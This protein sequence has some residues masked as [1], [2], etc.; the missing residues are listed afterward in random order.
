MEG[1]AS[2]DSMH[3][4][5]D[6]DTIS[7]PPEVVGKND[8][9]EEMVNV[10]ADHTSNADVSDASTMIIGHQSPPIP[11]PPPPPSAAA[12]GILS[13]SADSAVQ[14]L[15]AEKSLISTHAASKSPAKGTSVDSPSV[16]DYNSTECSNPVTA[17][18]E[19]NHPEPPGSENWIYQGEHDGYEYYRSS[20]K[21]DGQTYCVDQSGYWYIQNDDGS[22][23]HYNGTDD[24]GANNSAQSL[25][26][27]NA[28]GQPTLPAGSSFPL[29]SSSMPIFPVD[30]MTHLPMFP[31]NG[32]GQPIFPTGPHGRPVVPVDNRGL[33][34]FPRGADGHIIFPLEPNGKPVAPVNIYGVPVLPLDENGK[35]IVPYDT[36]GCAL[37][38]VASDGVTP[39]TDEEY[40]FSL[41][42]NDYYEKYNPTYN[43]QP[44]DSSVQPKQAPPSESV[45]DHIK[46]LKLLKK[47][48]PED[49]DLPPTPPP[50]KHSASDKSSPVPQP[51][52][53]EKE[54]NETKPVVDAALKAKTKRMLEMQLRFSKKAL[55]SRKSL[56]QSE[57]SANTVETEKV[58]EEG[59]TVST[60]QSEESQTVEKSTAQNTEEGEKLSTSGVVSQRSDE[61][62]PNS[63][64]EKAD[65]FS[66]TQTERLVDLGSNHEKELK[67]CGSVIKDVGTPTA[68]IS[69]HSQ[70][71]ENSELSI[72]NRSKEEERLKTEHNEGDEQQT[73]VDEKQISKKSDSIDEQTVPLSEHSNTNDVGSEC[74]RGK[75]NAETPAKEQ[76]KVAKGLHSSPQRS[77]RRHSDSDESRQDVRAKKSNA[78]RRSRSRHY[79]ISRSRSPCNRRSTSED[80]SPFREFSSDRDVRTSHAHRR[81][82]YY[83][84]RYRS[85]SHEKPLR[86]D[87]SYSHE[88]SD[89]REKT[90]RHSRSRRH[91]GSHERSPYRYDENVSGNGNV[92]QSECY[93]KDESSEMICEDSYIQRHEKHKKITSESPGSSSKRRLRKRSGSIADERKESKDRK[94]KKKKKKRH[95]RR[96][97]RRRTSERSDS[98]EKLIVEREVSVVVP[99]MEQMTEQLAESLDTETSMDVKTRE[100]SKG[101]SNNEFVT[102]D[103]SGYKEVSKKRR[104]MMDSQVNDNSCMSGGVESDPLSATSSTTLKK[105]ASP[106]DV[107]FKVVESPVASSA[108]NAASACRQADDSDL[109]VTFIGPKL[110]GKLETITKTETHSVVTGN[111][112]LCFYS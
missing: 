13:S 46:N 91:S 109:S 15:S 37:I 16:L 108:S 71:H 92:S 5:A 61:Q 68:E 41:Q 21:P 112:A 107:T 60:E 82:P 51:A 8:L 66:S 78:K 94:K 75:E 57:Q 79:R 93:D 24:N 7:E 20:D 30:P 69:R 89:S 84:Y 97:S 86:R 53:V 87:R 26:P 6:K 42:W 96:S 70:N 3:T 39:L 102:D 11:P 74:K 43:H 80:R 54:Q 52:N 98:E 14:S 58:T 36:M 64:A 19:G 99:A 59:I 90:Y 38:H 105:V 50:S 85:R 27:L 25:F 56:S 35:A 40:R 62:S 47:V 95:H 104:K 28:A 34:I 81:S 63:T 100:K 83:R 49:I 77:V 103:E 18:L 106:D 23:T 2:Q 44:T 1:V 45:D 32:A 88:R 55:L 29:D 4:V 67:K 110:D 12:D 33:P 31:V 101:S 72:T 73:N 48:R 76:E 17:S 10:N 65:V 9:Q 22:F 111:I